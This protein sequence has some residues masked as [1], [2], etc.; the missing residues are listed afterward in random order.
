MKLLVVEDEALLRHH[1]YTR[2]GENVLPRGLSERD[3]GH[4][5]AQNDPIG[6]YEPVDAQGT[7]VFYA[8]VPYAK[9]WILCIAIENAAIYQPITRMTNMLVILM[10]VLCAFGL[11]LSIA[12][13]GSIL[14]CKRSSS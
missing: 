14:R 1:L 2:L 6:H 9:N 4:L 3:I 7:T 8:S 13:A 11:L 12:L 5:A 10:S